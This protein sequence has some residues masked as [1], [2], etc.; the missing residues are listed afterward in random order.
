[1][2]ECT[3]FHISLMISRFAFRH[4]EI[5]VYQKQDIQTL[6]KRVDGDRQLGQ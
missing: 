4:G 3:F 5:E 6:H 2:P 1:M